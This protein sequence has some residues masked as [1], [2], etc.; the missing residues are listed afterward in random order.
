MH[1]TLQDKN[2][3][4]ILKSNILTFKPYHDTVRWP[5][6]GSARVEIRILQSGNKTRGLGPDK[7]AGVD[8]NL[9]D[10]LIRKRPGL[11]IQISLTPGCLTK[12]N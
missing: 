3:G 2:L 9:P 4:A 8:K 5:I 1:E 10:V 6:L 11:L 12:S 7:I